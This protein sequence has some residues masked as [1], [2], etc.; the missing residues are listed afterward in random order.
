MRITINKEEAEELKKLINSR[1][2][3]KLG[4]I[5]KEIEEQENRTISDKLKS[6]AE[7]ARKKRT[8]DTKKKIESAINLLEIGNQKITVYSVS[9][10]AGVSFNTCK[11]ENIKEMIEKREE[12]RV[13]RNK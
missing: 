11:K 10:L 1:S 8:E 9:K 7:T 2:R 3:I 4:R 13:K 5:V 12:T 6:G